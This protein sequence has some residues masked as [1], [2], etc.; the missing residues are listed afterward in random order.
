MNYYMPRRNETC[1]KKCDDVLLEPR[2]VRIL[3]RRYALTAT[4][5]KFLE[6]GIRMNP[7]SYV[8]IAI[9][10]N[11]N[12]IS[13]GPLTVRFHKINDTKLISLESA[14]VRMMMVESTL[15]RMFKLDPCI[16]LTFDRLTRL[17]ATVDIKFTKFFN[18]A[19]AITDARELPNAIR[20]SD[21]F[22]KHQLVDCE[23]VELVF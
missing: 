2:A 18:I 21:A 23:L 20:A 11:Y 6:I 16:E 13:V 10:D 4:E 9:G 19:S 12:F 15:H 5:F 7:P 8:E 17:T 3:G 14:D 1:E 22:N